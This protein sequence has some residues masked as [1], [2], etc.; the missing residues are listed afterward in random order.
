MWQM[1]G[2]GWGVLLDG[3]EC[4]PADG[5]TRRMF[6]GVSGRP[7]IHDIRVEIDRDGDTRF[8]YKVKNVRHWGTGRAERTAD[9][10]TIT[11]TKR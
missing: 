8:E 2:R 3:K 11:V 1:K 7:D 4:P 5:W 6:R 9:G 10:V